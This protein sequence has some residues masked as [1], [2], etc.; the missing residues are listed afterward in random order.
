MIFVVSYR[1]K[2]YLTPSGVHWTGD[3]NAWFYPR[4]KEEKI[5]FVHRI[6][7]ELLLEMIRLSYLETAE[8]VDAKQVLMFDLEGEGATGN[9]LAIL[10]KKE[11]L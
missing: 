2:Q 3:Q 11:T 1:Q 7:V 10:L 9:R 4:K 8:T 5:L 6:V